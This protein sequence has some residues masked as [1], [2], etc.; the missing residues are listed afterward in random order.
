MK[1]RPAKIAPQRKMRG[2]EPT[3]KPAAQTYTFPAPIRGWVLNESLAMPQPGGAAIL[4][5]WICTTTGI[6]ARGGAVKYADLGASVKSM[7]TYNSTT[8][9]FSAQLTRRFTKSQPWQTLT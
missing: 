8:E 9:K 3:Q 2:G 7:F 6:R 1:V 4:D 5:N